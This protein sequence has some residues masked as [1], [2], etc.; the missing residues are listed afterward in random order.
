VWQI[1][2]Q[3]NEGIMFKFLILGLAVIFNTASCQRA[4]RIDFQHLQITY[5]PRQTIEK[6]PSFARGNVNSL[7]TKNEKP[8]MQAVNIYAGLSLKSIGVITANGEKWFIGKDVEEEII[9]KTNTTVTTD[10]FGVEFGPINGFKNEEL[11]AAWNNQKRV[12]YIEI[13]S[14]TAKTNDGL[15]LGSSKQELVAI[16]GEPR[17]KKQNS[18]RYD[19]L[20]FEVQGIIFQFDDNDIITRIVLYSYL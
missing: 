6:H 14:P 9:T 7:F 12:L 10:L 15:T 19:N 5:A 11:I 8:N 16:L 20:E 3:I 1:H 13:L 17:I 2:C 18:F 4:N